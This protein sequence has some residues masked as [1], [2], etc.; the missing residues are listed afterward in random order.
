MGIV[1]AVQLGRLGP[2]YL[3]AANQGNNIFF[4]FCSLTMGVLYAI[5]PL[6]SIHIGAGE[7][8]KPFVL[9][10][11]GLWVALAL[12]LL[13]LGCMQVCIRY[14]HWFGQTPDINE[15]APQ[16]LEIL[17][18]SALPLLLFLVMREYSDGLG[19]TKIAMYLTFGGLFLNIFLN[20][21]LIYGNWGFPKLE[22]R[23]AALATLISRI[24]IMVIGFI[25][26]RRAKVFQE[27]RP[28]IKLKTAEIGANVANILKM[29]GPIAL[30]TFAEWGGFAVSGIMVGWLGANQTAAHA[31]ALSSA[32]FTYMLVS[33]L[34][35][36]GSIMVGNGYGEKNK[37]HILK[38]SKVILFLIVSIE[39][40]FALIFLFGNKYISAM[41]DLSPKVEIFILPLLMLAALFQIADGLQA[42]AMYML[43]GV[44]DVKW[45]SAISV[46]SYWFI[47]IPLSYFLGI[48]LKGNVYGIWTGFTAGLFIAA[49]LGIWRFY[50][51]LKNITFD[52]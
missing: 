21:L 50:K 40:I 17:C 31:A 20:Y 36:A 3:A 48:Y 46:I 42:G 43:R 5:S 4:M 10:K 24:V 34:A 32:A 51:N 30:Q 22:V 9:F 14:F 8:D 47:G 38:T 39:I 45:A 44:K 26:L 28:K 2:Q 11:S 49:I 52:K 12:F 41:Y 27:Y 19:F 23:G 29:G 13:H 16:Y 6:V 15:L 35:I 7:K 37:T 18:W 33:G 1:D 25:Y